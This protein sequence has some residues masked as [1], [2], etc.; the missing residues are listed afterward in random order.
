MTAKLFS[1][2][3]TQNAVQFCQNSNYIVTIIQMSIVTYI[4]IVLLPSPS[5]RQ[6]QELEQHTEETG[7]RS[8]R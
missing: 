1:G 3:I 6:V 5:K 4:D 2:Y 8:D 7:R